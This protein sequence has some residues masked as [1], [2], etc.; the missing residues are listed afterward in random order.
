L[1]QAYAKSAK[2]CAK[3]KT[4]P[5][6]NSNTERT[7]M[8]DTSE[9]NAAAAGTTPTSPTIG[10]ESVSLSLHHL[11][12]LCAAGLVVCFFMPWIKILF[13]RPSGLE[14]AKQGE[15]WI[16]LWAIPFM[17]VIT[18]LAGIAKINVREVAQVTG[19]LPF[20]ALMGPVFQHGK[21]IFSLLDFGAYAG[22]GL[23]LALLIL[24]HRLK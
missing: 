10:Q 7:T 4:L 5:V 21:E 11:V 18:V 6:S 24:P 15:V 17:G 22:L 14:L 12:S 19:A 20:A 8:P 1:R 9:Q 16:L 23:G 2:G 3:S 13:G